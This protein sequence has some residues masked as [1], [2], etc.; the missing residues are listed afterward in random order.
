VLESGF[1][2]G[3]E[4]NSGRKPSAVLVDLRAE[5]ILSIARDTGIFLRV[6]NLFDQRFFN[7]A[8]FAST[9]SPYYSRFPE[10]DRVALA[11]PTRYFAPRRIELG[12]RL[13]L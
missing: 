9:G 8:V 3:L 4:T 5:K 7:G 1:G 13:G 2:Y 10:T 11:D 6:F 12:F